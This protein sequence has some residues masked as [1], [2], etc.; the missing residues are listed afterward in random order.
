MRDIILASA[1][2]R[3]RELMRQAGIPFE[4]IISE[5]EEVIKPGSTAS[6]N[7]QGKGSGQTGRTGCADYRRRHGGGAGWE[8][9]WQT[10]R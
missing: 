8:N 3:R 2:P 9:T 10:N 7:R 5:E 4:V 6:G 1:S